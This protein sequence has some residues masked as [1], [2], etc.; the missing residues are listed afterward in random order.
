MKLKKYSIIIFSVVIV[1]LAFFSLIKVN[2]INTKSLSPV[3][4]TDDNKKIVNTEF[5]EDFNNFIQDNADVKI[6]NKENGDYLLNINDNNLRIKK[7]SELVNFI[8]DKFYKV[9][10]SLK[11]VIINIQNLI[12]KLIS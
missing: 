8:K 10:D 6:Y 1:L 4:N 5:G 2:I 11:S 9:T 12:Q 3:G 7:E